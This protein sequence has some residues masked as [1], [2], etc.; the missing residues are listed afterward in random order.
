LKALQLR[1]PIEGVR[2]CLAPFDFLHPREAGPVVYDS[3][4]TARK[5]SRFTQETS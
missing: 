1:R 4:M 5:T 3:R 2:L